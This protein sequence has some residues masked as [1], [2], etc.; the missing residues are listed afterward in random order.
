MSY[1]SQKSLS[2]TIR[3]VLPALLVLA[4]TTLATAWY[5]RKA[6]YGYAVESASSGN[7]LALSQT[8][9]H[10]ITGAKGIEP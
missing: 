7:N 1:S 4:V 3:T 6:S 8:L 10:D 9:P 2:L 5:V